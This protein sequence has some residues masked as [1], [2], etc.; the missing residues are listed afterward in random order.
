MEKVFYRKYRPQRFS[1]FIGQ[2]HVVQTLTNAISMGLISHAY[3][4]AGPKGTG[5]CVKFDTEIV[6]AATGEISSI[7][8]I[9]KRKRITLLTLC[10]NYKLKRVQPSR[11]I[12]DGIKPCYKVKTALGK[13]IEVTLAHPFLTIQGWKRLSEL[14]GGDFIALPRIL[15]VFG[16]KEMLEHQVRLIAHFLSEGS[17]SNPYHSPGFTNSDP[18]LVNDFISAV[19]KFENI[20][21]VKYDSGGARTPT[22]R[23]VQ[24][25]RQNWI[26][27]PGQ[28]KNSVMKFLKSLGLIQKSR[29]KKIPSVVFKLTKPLLALFLRTLFSGDG[30]VDY[31]NT[32]TI[33]YFSS[34]KKLVSQVQHLLLRFGI[35]SRIRD[36]PVK[37]KG[38]THSHWA[39]EIT[40]HESLLTFINEIGLIGEKE[41]KIQKLTSY[42]SAREINPNCDLIPLEVWDRKEKDLCKKT[43]SD[44]GR[45]LNYKT[46]K[47]FSTS[48]KYRP[49]R[50]KLRIC[51]EVF[52][53]QEI[54]N[55]ATSDLYWDKIIQIEYTGKYPV[56]DLVV[57]ETHNFVANDFIVHNTTLA[58]IFAKAVNCKNRK[59]GEFEPCGQCENCVE[60]Q[61]GRAVDLIEIDAASHRGIEEI[62][63]IKESIKFVPTKSKY[64]IYLIDEAHQLTKEAANALLKT[65]EEPPSYIIFILAT[66]EPEKIIPTI[67]SR[68]QR[69][70]FK[71]LKKEEI[72][73]KLKRI[74]K[75]E[76]INIENE[77]LE[78]IALNSEGALRDAESLL[79]QMVIIF[80]KNG[81]KTKEIKEI[82][83]IL[84]SNLFI[85]MVDFLIEKNAKGAIEYLNY[86]IDE[87]INLS[88][89]LKQLIKYLHQLMT[90]KILGEKDNPFLDGM[91][92][93]EKEILKNQAQ[94]LDLNS[95]K[96]ILELFLD[97]QQ[98]IK[99]TSFPSLPLELAIVEICE[100]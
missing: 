77:A 55:L 21:V 74:A 19:K 26:N 63:A 85:K 52:N 83:G 97:A 31:S 47:K 100:K 6:N 81:I 43:W 72:L 68:C 62:R 54:L 2:T 96:K 65:L 92:S 99:F 1:E 64:K 50:N 71:K 40:H 51:G 49:S 14:N 8:E 18:V 41:K 75:E 27:K 61:E 87:G 42:L 33:Y 89:F 15:P 34:S 17:V 10:S 59:K 32:P 57:P 46:P 56:Y 24:T 86:L 20:K 39:L 4:F 38:K 91:A 13:E 45:K 76:G 60:I 36:T 28:S 93:Q 12:Y 90:F 16:K 66:T 80:G 3:L 25:I 35:I 53:S 82:L 78:I 37:Y 44:I 67:S 58:R 23:A 29:D 95:L 70:Y 84:E 98:K 94:K 7:E 48:L 73:E 69:F 9:C 22:Y 30:G 79:D 5:K 88:E 11:Y